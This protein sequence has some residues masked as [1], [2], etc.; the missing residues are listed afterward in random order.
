MVTRV[1]FSPLSSVYTVK[2]S[3]PISHALPVFS[4]ADSLSGIGVNGSPSK[5][6]VTC[7]LA[8]QPPSTPLTGGTAFGLK[9]KS[10]KEATSFAAVP[11]QG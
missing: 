8:H 11:G 9:V 6:P 10:E 3:G 7:I 4:S 5:V 1:I 2:T